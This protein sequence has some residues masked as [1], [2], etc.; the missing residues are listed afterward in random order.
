M[1][2]DL[3]LLELIELAVQGSKVA[4][5]TISAASSKSK[6]RSVIHDLVC[7]PSPA[8]VRLGKD[9]TDH[10]MG[11]A[12][13]GTTN[14]GARRQS[15]LPETKRDLLELS[16]TPVLSQRAVYADVRRCLVSKQ[17]MYGRA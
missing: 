5:Y 1:Q 11:R 2:D 14:H 17:R 7:H 15:L 13:A 9:I 3:M 16:D 8:S 4:E 12:M 6:L 10:L